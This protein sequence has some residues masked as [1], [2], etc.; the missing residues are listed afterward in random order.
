MTGQIL[1]EQSHRFLLRY[2]QITNVQFIKE[3]LLKLGRVIRK[4]L[5][6]MH[7][8]SLN[9]ACAAPMYWLSVFGRF[10]D[11]LNYPYWTFVSSYT[12][13]F[14]IQL[15]HQ[16]GKQMRSIGFPKV[17]D[18]FLWYHKLPVLCTW[19]DYSLIFQRFLM[20]FP[21]IISIPSSVHGLIRPYKY[22][23]FGVTLAAK[24]RV[25]R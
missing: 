12:T 7:T 15:T 24:V 19:V 23:L 11:K 16:F 8:T 18:V 17:F 6:P 14:L 20:Y 10:M 2:L 4:N 5:D 1:G 21:S 3:N 13:C 25:S 9:N 22:C